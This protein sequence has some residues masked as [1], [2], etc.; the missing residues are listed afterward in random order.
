MATTDRTQ[1]VSESPTLPKDRSG[2]NKFDIADLY[3]GTLSGG[4][5]SAEENSES[6][7]DE[8]LRKAYLWIVN[9]AIISPYY[10]IEYNKGA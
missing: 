6:G 9:N 7:L 10:D 5:T 8:K 1:K 2:K 3:H 4:Q